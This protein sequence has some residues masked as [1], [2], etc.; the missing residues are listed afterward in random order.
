MHLPIS[1]FLTAMSPWAVGS[2][3]ERTLVYIGTVGFVFLIAHFTERKKYAWRM[4]IEEIWR[5]TASIFSAIMAAARAAYIGRHRNAPLGQST[6][7]SD[8]RHGYPR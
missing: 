1:Q 3:Q 7:M 5:Q 6:A 4:A 2:W 8:V